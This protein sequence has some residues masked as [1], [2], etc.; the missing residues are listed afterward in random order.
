V[1]TYVG[2]RIEVTYDAVR[3][4]HAAECV[5]GLPAVFDVSRR[6]WIEPDG[7]DAEELAAVIRRCPTGALHYKLADGPPEKP[8]VPTRVRMPAGGPV[9]IAGD[10]EIDGEPETRAALCRCG[11]SQD[12]PFCDGSG[13]CADWQYEPGT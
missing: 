9:L 7:A 12:E 4:R 2:E 13:A 8:V 10:L 5:R 11:R 3:C 6:P 1:K